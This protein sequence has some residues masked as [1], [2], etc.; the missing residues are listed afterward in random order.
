MCSRRMFRGVRP[1]LPL[2]AGFWCDF[3]PRKINA[4]YGPKTLFF[5][6]QRFPYLAFEDPPVRAPSRRPEYLPD[7]VS[8]FIEPHIVGDAYMI[9][10]KT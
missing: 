8:G 3:E 6:N 10:K 5:G 2:C 1:P 4:N 7:G 9:I